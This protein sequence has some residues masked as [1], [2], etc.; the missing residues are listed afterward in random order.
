MLA[1]SCALPSAF[2][3]CDD[4]KQTFQANQCCGATLHHPLANPLYSP[5][6][7]TITKH[8]HVMTQLARM[9]PN[10]ELSAQFLANLPYMQ[11]I[12]THTAHICEA[13]DAA[14]STEAVIQDG[15]SGDT[16]YPFGDIKVLATVGEYD[17]KTGYML[18]GVPDGMGA[19]LLD[20]KTVRTSLMLLIWIAPPNSLDLS[21]DFA[22]LIALPSFVSAMFCHVYWPA[23]LL[24]RHAFLALP[25]ARAGALRLPE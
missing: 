8:A 21:T 14:Y 5:L 3:S 17:A 18:V 6:K 22:Y 4:L 23:A 25:L 2:Q 19:Y 13:T 11:P 20:D 24:R 12:G 7:D 1:L 16:D 10:T 15:V 9:D